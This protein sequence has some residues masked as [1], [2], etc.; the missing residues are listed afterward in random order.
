MYI[1]QG[2]YIHKWKQ[3]S[4]KNEE[5][6]SRSTTNTGHWNESRMNKLLMTNGN[7]H[8]GLLITKWK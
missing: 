2:T 6:C 4:H 5:D 7:E 3:E 8:Q 1:D